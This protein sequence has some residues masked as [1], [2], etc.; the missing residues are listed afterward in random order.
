MAAGT[1]FFAV[2]VRAAL[3]FAGVFPD[4]VFFAAAF[5][6]A[7]FFAGFFPAV[8]F[9]VAVV[10]A[11]AFFAA[12]FASVAPWPLP[13]SA[14]L[15]SPVQSSAASSEVADAVVRST[16]FFATMGAAPSPRVI[17]LADRAGTINRPMT[18]GNGA[19]RPPTPPRTR[20]RPACIRC[21]QLPAG[22]S[23]ARPSR[24]FRGRPTRH[25]GQ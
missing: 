12:A 5:L 25:S 11:A 13:A 6:A 17:L 7:A 22:Y 9:P 4:A 16:V 23:A 2:L 15:P 19:R 14:P 1:A 3:F 10:A 21:A 18:R 8:A 20:T 24:A